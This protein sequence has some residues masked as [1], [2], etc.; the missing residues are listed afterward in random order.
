MALQIANASQYAVSGTPGTGTITL[1]AVVTGYITL[2]T[3]MSGLPVAYDAVD[4]IASVPVREVGY[5][6]LTYSAGTWTL[7]R[8]LVAS[9]TGSLL[10]LTSTAIISFTQLAGDFAAVYR[11]DNVIRNGPLDVWQRGTSSLTATTS[12]AYTADGMIVLPTGASVTASQASGRGPTKYSL[13]VTGATSVTD[14]IIKQRVE[15]IISVRLNSRTVTV[16]IQVYNNTGGSITP[17]LT[18][19]YANSA[20]NWSSSTVDP[21]CNGVSLQ[22]CANG[23][24]T[25]V[26]YTY[27]DSGYAGNGLE[28]AFDFGNN[29]SSSG[30]TIQVTEFDVS[31]TPFALAGAQNPAPIEAQLRDIS[32]EL[33]FCQRYFNVAATGVPGVYTS[34]HVYL[35][36]RYPVIMRA[37]PTI[38]VVTSGTGNDYNY[39]GTSGYNFTTTIGSNVYASDNS[40]VEIQIS[41]S[42]STPSNGQAIIL[43][44]GILYVSAEL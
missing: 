41:S 18:V 29:F 26:S 38:S 19:K 11:G 23:A 28:F 40:G 21:N 15:S 9:T 22:A 8:N 25:K 6:V 1:G 12:G 16:Q 42:G 13:M 24:W 3:S 39:P 10:L 14:L 36:Y 35:G 43:L 4:T 5:G 27:T 37:Q 44:Q 32:R 33:A 2:P 7:T 30:K 34:S 31:W 17:T 20:D